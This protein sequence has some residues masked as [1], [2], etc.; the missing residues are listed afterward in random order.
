MDYIPVNWDLILS[1]VNWAIIIL[2]LLIAGFVVHLA[3]PQI[4]VNF[5][6]SPNL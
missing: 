6:H 5:N 2:M 3:L 4:P 1:P